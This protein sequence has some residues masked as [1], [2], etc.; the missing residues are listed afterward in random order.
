MRASRLASV[1]NQVDRGAPSAPRLRAEYWCS[2]DHSTVVPFAAD[3][4]P[5]AEWLCYR[6]GSPAVS[7]RGT[8]PIATRP[9]I[10]PRTPYGFLMMRRTEADGDRLLEEAV[11]ELRKN[12]RNKV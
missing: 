8:A 9:R 2:N 7:E 6:C 4:E 5:P 12:R 3:I 10:F 11:R 1:S